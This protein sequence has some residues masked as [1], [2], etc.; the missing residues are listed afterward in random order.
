MYIPEFWAGVLSVVSAEMIAFIAVVIYAVIK[1][2]KKNKE[3]RKN[4]GTRID[5]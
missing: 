3:E 1:S 5:E 2:A 4:D